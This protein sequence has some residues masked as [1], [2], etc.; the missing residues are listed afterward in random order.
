MTDKDKD[1]IYYFF[2]VMT[3]LPEIFVIIVSGYSIFVSFTCRMLEEGDSKYSSY[4]D[5]EE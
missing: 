4:Y 5:D 3:F 2:L 1:S